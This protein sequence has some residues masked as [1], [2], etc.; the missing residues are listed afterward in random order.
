MLGER[1]KRAGSDSVHKEWT[2][3]IS[4]IGGSGRGWICQLG[5]VWWG[6]EDAGWGDWRERV[7]RM[8]EEEGVV[9]VEEGLKMRDAAAS[10]AG[11][12]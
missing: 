10:R 12:E 4:V 11:G 6:R 1:E 8:A 5:G 2:S 7:E 3:G 9:D